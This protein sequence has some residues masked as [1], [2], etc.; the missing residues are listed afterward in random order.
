MT[1]GQ[2]H[3]KNHLEDELQEP[4]GHQPVLFSS[5]PPA[6]SSG[7]LLRVKCR[8]DW[9]SG[10]PVS[11]PGDTEG[12]DRAQAADTGLRFTA[13]A[14]ER[15]LREHG[16]ASAGKCAH[17]RSRHFRGSQSEHTHSVISGSHNEH[18]HM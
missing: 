12:W 4:K 6:L 13:F 15:T 7:P 8:A 1:E 2:E 10:M 3:P 11:L 9:P 14:G 16:A 18:K 5:E 17:T